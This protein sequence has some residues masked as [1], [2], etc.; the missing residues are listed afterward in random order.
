MTRSRITLTAF[1]IGC[2]VKGAL[3]IIGCVAQPEWAFRWIVGYDPLV[4]LSADW[5]IGLLCPHSGLAP[6]DCSLAVFD[7]WMVVGFGVECAGA[8]LLV[9][10]LL[11]VRRGMADR[12]QR[13]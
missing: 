2:F 6:S 9:Q 10:V 5:I 13:R 8:A 1:V 7:A 11:A 4:A 12:T 3:L